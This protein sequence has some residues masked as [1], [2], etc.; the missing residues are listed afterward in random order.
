[1]RKIL[2]KCPSCGNDL[3]ITRL[4]CAACG[5][6][7]LG[8]YAPCPFCQLSPESTSFLLTFLQCRGNVKEMEREM[9]ISYWTI[10]RQIDELIDELGLEA[11][12]AEQTDIAEREIDILQQVREGTLSA[13][14]AAEQLVRLKGSGPQ[15]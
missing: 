14:Q 2:E 3:T 5:T 1:M 8:Q 9:G 15:K 4:N 10:R 13:A 11:S 7:V 6:I 12:S